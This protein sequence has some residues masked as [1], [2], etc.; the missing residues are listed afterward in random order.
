MSLHLPADTDLS[1]PQIK[2]ITEWNEA[3]LQRNVDM[4]VKPLHKDF[5]RV[6]YPRSMGHPEQNKDEWLEE[7][8]GIFGLAT[9]FD[10]G[11]IPCYSNFLNLL[12]RRP[13]IPL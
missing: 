7:I 10:V 4:A 8:T 2:L 1:S 12:C 3:F 9:G 6:V 13:S 5:R 11:H